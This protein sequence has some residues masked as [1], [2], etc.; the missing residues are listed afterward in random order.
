M[1]TQSTP[2]PV[3][4]PN[5]TGMR[6][7]YS[8]LLGQAANGLKGKD[9]GLAEMLRQLKGHITELG[10]LYYAGNTACVDEFLQLYCVE[11]DARA[12]IAKTKGSAS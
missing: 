12:A 11:R 7:N 8:G 9:P 1:S 5:H 2:G 10:Q 4:A 3:L 6:I